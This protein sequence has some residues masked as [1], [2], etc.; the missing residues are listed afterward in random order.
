L[1]WKKTMGERVLRTSVRS[2]AVDG[3]AGPWLRAYAHCSPVALGGRDGGV[4]LLLI[5]THSKDPVN[6]SIAGLGGVTAWQRRLEWH[7]TAGG[8]GTATSK[9]SNLNGK[10]LAVRSSG[11]VSW[12]LPSLDGAVVP[13]TAALVI[14]PSSYTFVSYPAGAA[15]CKGHR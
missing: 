3:A 7:L 9:I 10:A 1:L 6:V 2:S 4:S 8:D 12:S 15:A 11:G 13:S 5:N 14:Q